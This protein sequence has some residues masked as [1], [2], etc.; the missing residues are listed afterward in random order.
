MLVA[1]LNEDSGRAGRRIYLLH[2]HV[3]VEGMAR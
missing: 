2:G 3:G 1:A